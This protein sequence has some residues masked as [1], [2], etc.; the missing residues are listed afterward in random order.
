MKVEIGC[1]YQ[2][3]SWDRPAL[4]QLPR[5]WVLEENKVSPVQWILLWIWRVLR[6]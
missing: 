6:G 2:G 3:P 5:H 1:K 4:R